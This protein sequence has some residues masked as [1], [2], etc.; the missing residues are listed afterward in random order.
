MP[1]ASIFAAGFLAVAMLV[2]FKVKITPRVTLET[3][4]RQSG[5]AIA[6]S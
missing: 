1:I 4:K 6:V 2:P 5:G 3:G